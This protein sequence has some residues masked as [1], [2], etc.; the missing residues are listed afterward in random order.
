MQI[1]NSNSFKLGEDRMPG[2]PKKKT[3]ARQA[4]LKTF[5]QTNEQLRSEMQA[6][7]EQLRGEMQAGNEQLRGEMQAGNEQ[8]R[9]EM[10]AGNEQLRG[11]MQ[12]GNEQLRSEMQAGNE[13]LRGEMQAGNEQ[14]RGEMQVQIGQLRSEMQ[15]GNEQLRGEMQVQIGQLRSEMQAGNEQLRAEMQTGFEQVNTRISSVEKNL[16]ALDAFTRENL[17]ALG[18]MIPDAGNQAFA[19]IDQRAKEWHDR[20]TEVQAETKRTSLLQDDRTNNLEKRV[21][22]LQTEVATLRQDHVEL[23]QQVETLTTKPS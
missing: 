5:K 9:G 12:A 21:E 11:E 8:L 17:D 19:R 1:N 20:L 3:T 6:G 7:N 16:A 10:Q 18:K 2:K 14:L 22:R 4:S 15:A 13:Q 23:Q